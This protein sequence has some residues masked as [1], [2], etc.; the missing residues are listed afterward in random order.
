MNAGLLFEWDQRKARRNASKHAVTFE[1]AATVF[2]D[3]LS[4]TIPDP[5][6]SK[7]DDRWV[8]VGLSCR[9][10]LV[11]VVHADRGRRVRLISARRAT[12]RERRTYE[13]GLKNED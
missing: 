4:L 9:L 6:H 13:E 5:L 7:G 12:P 2:A 11:V 10:R 8:T 1:E 3:P